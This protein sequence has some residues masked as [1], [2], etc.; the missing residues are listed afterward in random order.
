MSTDE[1]KGLVER[2]FNVAQYPEVAPLKDAIRVQGMA[3]AFLLSTTFLRDKFPN[4]DVQRHA[5]RILDA[6]ES[7]K[8]FL[9]VDSAFDALHF[10]SVHRTEVPTS[11][12]PQCFST[13]IFPV[14]WL[15]M[16]SSDPV[17]QLGAIIHVGSHAADAAAGRIP[18]G[19]EN[20]AKARALAWE[21]EFYF[22]VAQHIQ[23]WIPNEGQRRVMGLYPDGIETSKIKM[24]IW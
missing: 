2:L 6:V 16:F 7:G 19:F 1:L 23:G 22:A 8:V 10:L 5:G 13:I 4:V 11:S 18:P 12:P 24:M 3:T 9:S 20:E 17:T 14:N 21:A 15:E